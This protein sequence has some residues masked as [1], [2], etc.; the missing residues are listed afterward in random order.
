M[1]FTEHG[2]I[3]IPKNLVETFGVFRI[4]FL[5]KW[6]KCEIGS[7]FLVKDAIFRSNWLEKVRIS[8]YSAET[9]RI[10]RLQFIFTAT[11]ASNN[12]KF[13]VV[14]LNFN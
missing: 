14:M 10:V 12:A 7:Y 6:C 8:E 11:I 5:V 1:I 9:S 2:N 13:V 3:R 4:N